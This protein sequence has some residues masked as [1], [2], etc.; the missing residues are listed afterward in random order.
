MTLVEPPLATPYR[1]FLPAECAV[2]YLD[3]AGELTE[4]EARYPRPS[5]D[6]LVEMYRNMV[7]G[8]RF[9]DQATALTKQGRLAVYPS[10]AGQ[11]ACQVGGGARACD[12]ATGC[13]R[14]TAT[15][16]RSSP[17]AS[18]RSRCS[19]CCAATGT[20]ATTRRPPHA[21]R[22]APRWPPS[23]HAAGLAYGEAPQGR[24]HRGAGV[25][26]RRRHQRGRLPR[27]AELRRRVQGAGRVP[28]AE[29][30]VRDQRAAGQADRGADL[31]A[32]GRRLRHAAPS[33]STATTRSPCSPC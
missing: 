18:T 9:D 14:P 13:S 31:G 8:R 21:P 26:R 25:R 24:G 3:A 19:P 16:W 6:R 33:R 15:P 5:D 7:L 30:R 27:G 20:A 32:Q 29:Q 11:E 23:L 10:A 12:P 2:Q 22:S 1:K 17:A 28:G 4:S